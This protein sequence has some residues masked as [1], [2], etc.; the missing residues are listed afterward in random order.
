MRNK[1]YAKVREEGSRAQMAKR[2]LA[3]VMGA[4][5][6]FASLIVLRKAIEITRYD[7][8]HSVPFSLSEAFGTLTMYLLALALAWLGIRSL[9]FAL[10]GKH[11]PISGWWRLVLFSILFFIPGF[12]FSLPLTVI[13]ARYTWPGDG[14]SAL[15]AME[16]SFYIG[17]AATVICF[18]VLLKKDL[19]R[20]E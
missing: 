10:S 11:K 6:V 3:T 14:Q 9:G 8:K 19:S 12:I 2:A 13:W 16:V 1:V 5:A 15:A 4:I 17:V 7:F 18:G 20:P